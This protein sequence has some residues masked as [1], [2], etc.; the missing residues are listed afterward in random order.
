MK[1]EVFRFL[2]ENE[3]GAKDHF[4]LPVFY[5]DDTDLESHVRACGEDYMR[6]NALGGRLYEAHSVNNDY[7]FVF[8]KEEEF[9]YEALFMRVLEDG[10]TERRPV[11]HR[12]RAARP[13]VINK[14][15]IDEF[16]RELPKSDGWEMVSIGL[17]EQ[18]HEEGAQEKWV[19]VEDDRGIFSWVPGLLYADGRVETIFGTMVDPDSPDDLR[20]FTNSPFA[21]FTITK[22][23]AL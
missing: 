14:R 11:R 6:F 2:Y 8:R 21:G 10:T 4:N 7:R 20:D 19:R 12:Y 3:N 9:I 18:C 22:S 13:L 5:D 23:T 1:K 15:L 17:V 16:V